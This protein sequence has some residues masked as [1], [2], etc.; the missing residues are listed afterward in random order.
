MLMYNNILNKNR[1]SRDTRIEIGCILLQVLYRARKSI[2]YR[3]F[4]D[5][6]QNMWY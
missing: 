2:Y 4:L 5:E 6:Y 1:V 3:K